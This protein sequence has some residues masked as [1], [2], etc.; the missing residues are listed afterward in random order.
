MTELKM[1]PLITVIVVNYKTR[2]ITTRCLQELYADLGTKNA[3][4]IVVD[5]ASDDGSVEAIR[6]HFP[7]AVV[8]A[9]EVN[10]G[11]GAANNQ[12][13]ELARGRYLLFLNSDAFV[14]PG[15]VQ[16]LAE[17]L[18]NHDNV[19]LVGPKL[20]NEDGSLQRSCWRFPSALRSWA[21]ALWISG[22]FADHPVIG[23]YRFWKHDE[24]REVDFVIGACMLA[25]REVYEAIGGFDLRF[26]MYQEEADWQ[27]R[28]RAH[29]WSVH[30]VPEAGATHL[31]GASG[32]DEIPKVNRHFL[33]SLDRYILKHHGSLGFLSMRMAQSVGSFLRA[34]VWVV[35]SMSPRWRPRAAMKVEQYWGRFRHNLLTR[36]PI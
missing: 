14:H 31:G 36:R 5:N 33:E 13:L 29:G 4:I 21:D 27:K 34:I 10:V 17:Y 3:E 26:F 2:K 24:A 9:N 32:K 1:A 19:G 18:E 28:M 6:G 35:I 30:L 23:D 12:A 25:R 20:E 7:A 15:C 22:L 11:F 16:M 8:I